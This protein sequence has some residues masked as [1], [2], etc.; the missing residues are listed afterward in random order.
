MKILA[1]TL[2]FLCIVEIGISE[3]Y[4]PPG[5]YVPD[6][7]TAITIAEAVLI[8]VYGKK[9]IESERPFKATLEDDVWTVAGTLYCRDGKPATDKP[10]TC[11]G[12]VAVVQI[13]KADARII[14][15]IHYK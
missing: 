7:K 14:S 15:M 5:G 3:G 4:H 2:L 6:S 13:S 12:G 11:V 9:H 10:P 1:T 8:P